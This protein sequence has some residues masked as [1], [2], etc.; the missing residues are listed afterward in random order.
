MV[1]GVGGPCDCWRDPRVGHQ[2]AVAP[3]GGSPTGRRASHQH[4]TSRSRSIALPPRSA[5]QGNA[6]SPL[7]R[8][9]TLNAL[10]HLRCG[11]PLRL[12]YFQCA[13]KVSNESEL[14]DHCPKALPSG[15]RRGFDDETGKTAGCLNVWVGHLRGS[16]K[17][18]LLDRRFVARTRMECSASRCA[19]SFGR[20]AGVVVLAGTRLRGR[21][22][23]GSTGDSD[24]VARTC[25]RTGND[26]L[27]GRG[28]IL[29]GPPPEATLSAPPPGVPGPRSSRRHAGI[30]AA[31]ARSFRTGHAHARPPW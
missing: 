21:R 10:Q 31:P 20:A 24:E 4:I 28:V 6:C 14:V 18:A 16:Y 29:S 9:V 11:N 3:R 26:W 30:P 22:R 19:A 2:V 7:I 23:T 27:N 12:R 8:S 5:Q 13:C 25:A 1:E 17:V 15:E